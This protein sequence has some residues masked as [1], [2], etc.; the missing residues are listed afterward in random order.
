LSQDFNNS[1]Q[2]ILKLE[3]MGRL[4]EAISQ[5][6]GAKVFVFGGIP[7]EEVLA[8]V[9]WQKR[10]R[11][12]ARVTEVI[13]PSSHRVEATCPYFG[14]C[15]GCQWQHISYEHQLELKHRMVQD[16][17]EQTG[18]IL[19][20]PVSSVVP[21]PQTLGYRNHARFTVGREGSLGYV[22]RQNRRFL[23]IEQ[24]QLMHPW[25]NQ[26]LSQLQG[27]CG[28]TTQLS[29]RYGV[30]TGQWLIQPTLRET[31]V[32]LTSGQKHY[33]ESL[34]GNCFRV[35]AASFFQVN[36][37]QAEHMVQLV[38]DRLAL[39]GQELVVDAY[40]GVGTFAV[41]LA[42]F[43]R[44]V[45][46]I[47]E[48]ASAIQNARVNIVGLPNIELAQS[49]TEALLESL[50]QVPDALVLDPP[51]TG[52]H[53]DALKAI[54][55]RPPKRMVYISCDPW[56]LARDLRILCHGPFTLEEV[57][58]IDLFPQT[59]HIECIA[60]LSYNP[61]RERAFQARQQLVLAS[62][63]PRRREIMADMG[64]DFRV[65]PSSV[66]ESLP[67]SG[68]PIA[69]AQEQALRKAQAVASTLPEGIVIAADTIVAD[70]DDILGKPAS[71]DEAYALLS[72]LKA[73][74][75]RVVT[76]LALVDAAT[77]EEITGYR[78]SRVH[79]RDYTDQ[80]ISAYIA[81][82]HPMDKAGAY[83]IQ[84][85]G[86][87]PVARVKGCYL[88][89]VG[90]PACTLLHLLHQM[91]VYPVINPGWVPPG[92]CPDCHLLVRNSR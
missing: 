88:N 71:E 42:P 61:E 45:I 9:I 87:H 76:G 48:S 90:L 25:I 41:L 68:N 58:P 80:E 12:A 39:S 16:A 17:L 26:A 53:P 29:I 6:N 75:H 40:A 1:T 36:T 74:E 21:A 11:V 84:D 4:G 92:K 83:G 32:P 43:A 72:R 31:K 57:L 63:S 79:M 65:V 85:T 82:G 19:N 56:A 28:E 33:E 86:F 60:T 46:A 49:K 7:G 10:N 81:S 50:P 38:K 91:G 78:M 66:E 2:L 8:E 18:G 47:E 62:E 24:C 34:H 54:I 64:L 30:N 27:R 52:C 73:N 3:G 51:R 77:G 22:N 70:G 55:F 35:S 89:V 59:H 69:I 14:T 13:R 37:G 15:T 23:R 5:H 44:K 67:S 20:A